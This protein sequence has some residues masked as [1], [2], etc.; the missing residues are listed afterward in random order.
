MRVVIDT[1]IIVSAYLGGALEGI[2][3]AWKSGKFTLVV[4]REI[5]EE[6]L[7]VLRRP[8]FRIEQVEVDDFAALLLDRAEFVIPLEAFTVVEDDPTDDKFLEAA[9]TGKAN[10]IISGDAHLLDLKSFRN[11]PIITARQFVEKLN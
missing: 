11:I 8:K 6:Y 7:E 9:I 5:A 10:L 3:I 4:S 1:N 2:I